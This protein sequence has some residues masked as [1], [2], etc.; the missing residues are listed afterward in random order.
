[1]P[2]ES[3][4]SKEVRSVHDVHHVWAHLLQQVP[5]SQPQGQW[6][7]PYLQEDDKGRRI[8]HDFHLNNRH[9]LLKKYK[10]LS[11]GFCILGLLIGG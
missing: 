11:I 8:S 9:P 1:M 5:A 7:V 6:E 4:D 10:Y 2:G 3:E